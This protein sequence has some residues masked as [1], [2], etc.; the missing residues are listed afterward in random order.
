MSRLNVPDDSDRAELV[1]RMYESIDLETAIRDGRF[2]SMDELADHLKDQ[3]ELMS[4]ALQCRTWVM[5]PDQPACLDLKRTV[6][7]L[8]P[9]KRSLI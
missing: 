3:S 2:T 9:N 7:R 6:A 1:G 4:R 5:N 8:R